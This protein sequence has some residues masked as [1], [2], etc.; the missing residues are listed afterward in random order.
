MKDISLIAAVANNNA[1]GH[2]Q[3]LLCYMP[4]DLK[5]FKELT[6]GHTIVM[7]RRTFESLP[8]G[9]LPNRTNIVL[10]RNKEL[11]FPGTQIVSSMAQAIDATTDDAVFLIGGASVYREGLAFANRMYLTFIHHTFAEA[12]TFFPQWDPEQWQEVGREDFKA[13]EK[14]PY[15]YSFVTFERK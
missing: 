10:T 11:S 12:D 4:A 1:I 9:A 5:H 8:K 3:D 6:S 2:Q 7:G 15:D 14:N 13:D